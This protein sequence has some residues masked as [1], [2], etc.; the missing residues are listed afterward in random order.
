MASGGNPTTALEKPEYLQHEFETS[1]QVVIEGESL[2]PNQD[3]DQYKALTRK[4]LF[5]LDTRCVLQ[6]SCI[7][8]ELTRFSQNRPCPRPSVPMLPPRPNKR[9]Q[10]QNLGPRERSRAV[11][12]SICQWTRHLLCLLHRGRVTQQPGPQALQSQNLAGLSHRRLGPR[13]HVFGLCS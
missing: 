6:K 3:T 1:S 13:R 5:K 10:R 12:W 9:R 8:P 11:Q 2:P 4:L 7:S